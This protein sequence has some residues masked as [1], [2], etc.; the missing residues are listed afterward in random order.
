M[1]FRAWRGF[2]LCPLGG[3]CPEDSI[4]LSA[5]F[6]PLVFLVHRNPMENRGW[7]SVSSMAQVMEEETANLLL[8]TEPEGHWLDE[9]L[10]CH[11]G[12][13]LN[14]AFSHSLEFLQQAKA[15]TAYRVTLVG[16]GDVGGTL[17]TALK[18]LGKEISEIQIYDPNQDLCRRYEME[19]NQVLTFDGNSAPKITLCSPEALFHCDLFL[20]TA[21]RG[22]PPLG[23]KVQDVRMEQFQRNRQMLSAYARQAREAGFQGLF[24]QISDPVDHLARSVFL[25]SNRNHAGEF[26][27]KGL[28]PEQIQGFGLGVMAAR[29]A[30]YA[31]KLHLDFSHGQVYGPHG[32]DLIVANSTREYDPAASELLRE[33]TVKANLAVRALGFKPYI[34]P[35]LSSAALSI[36]ALLRG[37]PHYGAVPIGRAYFGCQSRMTSQGLSI[38]RE[39]L[40]KALMDEIRRV[41]EKLEGFSYD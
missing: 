2:C 3:Q 12:T 14:T 35:A 1:E 24:C 8:P 20:F 28:L 6:S 39:A 40:P 21:S 30:Y 37:Q 31:E 19:L 4:P 27:G 34:A 36:L 38:Q 11:G 29:A 18:L 22:V 5:P 15:K 9:F 26:D 41:H 32:S 17:L 13:V 23:A 16:L 33:A 10:S 7:F 25:D